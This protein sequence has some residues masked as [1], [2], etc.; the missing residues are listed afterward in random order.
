[1]LR[2]CLCCCC[3][4]SSTAAAA[5]RARASCSLLKRGWPFREPRS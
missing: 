2:C 4:G 5:A 3:Y 1:L